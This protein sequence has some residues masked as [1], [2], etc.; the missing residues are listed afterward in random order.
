MGKTDTL[1]HI[2]ARGKG[3]F[4]FCSIRPFVQNLSNYWR[5]V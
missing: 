3:V 2:L 4:E 1:Y 5:G